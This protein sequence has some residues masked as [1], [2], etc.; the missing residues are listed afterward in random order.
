[1]DEYL[2]VKD[3]ARI[4]GIHE[5]TVRRHIQ[6]GRLRAVRIGRSVRVRPQDLQDYAPAEKDTGPRPFSFDDPLWDFIGSI[7]DEGPPTDVSSD[8]H[9]HVAD[10]IES[11]W[12]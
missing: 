12:R 6:Q 9:R 1:M 11:R 8:I 10:A 7:S 5:V 2:T 4:C 3:V